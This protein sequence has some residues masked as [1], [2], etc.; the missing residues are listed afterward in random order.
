MAQAGSGNGKDKKGRQL[1]NQQIRYLPV[2][3]G[4]SSSSSNHIMHRLQGVYLDHPIHAS[5][6]SQKTND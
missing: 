1:F 5:R 3:A 6:T 4:Y 2:G